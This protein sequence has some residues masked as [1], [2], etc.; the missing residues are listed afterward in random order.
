MLIS[1]PTDTST[2]FGVFQVIRVLQLV[3]RD[4]YAGAEP[5]DLSDVAQ[6]RNIDAEHA[7]AAI[8]LSWTKSLLSW[9]KRC[10]TNAGSPCG[11]SPMRW[12]ALSASRTRSSAFHFLLAMLGDDV[13]P[14]KK[15]A[16]IDDKILLQLAAPVTA[17]GVFSSPCQPS[18]RQAWRPGPPAPQSAD[19]AS[20][21]AHLAKTPQH[22][23]THDSSCRLADVPC[24]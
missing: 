20:A 14:A 24:R 11:I 18:S 13:W 3:W 1:M 12:R 22:R 16:C 23:R 6:V 21:S 4:A 9:A 2:I 8:L 5:R 10:G 7:C 15:L 19:L 17:T